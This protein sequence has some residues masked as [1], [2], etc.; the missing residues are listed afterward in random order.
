MGYRPLKV[1][2]T[3]TIRKLWYGFIIVFYSNYGAILCRLR[4]T[5]TYLS[6][7]AKLLYPPPVFIDD[8]YTHKTKMIG[9]I[10]RFRRIPERDCETDRRTDGRTDRHNCYYQYRALA[11]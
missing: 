3:G 2:E 7:I 9:L 11:V 5:T 6:K 8:V 1:I 10:C 4:D